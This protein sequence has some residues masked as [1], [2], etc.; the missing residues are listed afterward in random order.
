MNDISQY[1]NRKC[2]AASQGSQKKI[3]TTLLTIISQALGFLF[4]RNLQRFEKRKETTDCQQRRGER[5][6]CHS[7]L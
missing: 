2:S 5:G 6:L 7:R 4:P 3:T 1:G